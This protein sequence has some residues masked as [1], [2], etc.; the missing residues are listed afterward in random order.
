M[1]IFIRFMSC[2]FAGG[3]IF[4]FV[5]HNTLEGTIALATWLIAYSLAAIL[6]EMKNG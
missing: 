4:N 1:V 6:E 3:A 5:H 2:V